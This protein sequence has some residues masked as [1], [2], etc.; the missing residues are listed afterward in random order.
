MCRSSRHPSRP[1]SAH[2]TARPECKE[3]RK[4]W[5]PRPQ[6]TT[7]CRYRAVRSTLRT[8]G[9]P[10]RTSIRISSAFLPPRT[11]GCST[12]IRTCSLAVG[13]GPGFSE[14]MDS[15][16]PPARRVGMQS[17]S[18]S[19]D[20]RWN[21]ALPRSSSG[22]RRDLLPAARLRSAPG[23]GQTLTAFLFLKAVRVTGLQAWSARIDR[24]PTLQRTR[25]SPSL[26]PW[27]ADVSSAWTF[28]GRSPACGRCTALA[29]GDLLSALA[30]S[31]RRDRGR[32]DSRR[33][34]RLSRYRGCMVDWTDAVPCPPPT[35]RAIV[36]RSRRGLERIVVPITATG[37]NVC[38][39][40]VR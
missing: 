23:C 7:I 2:S 5:R 18:R 24:N 20:G 17:A 25:R 26:N 4:R 33:T 8:H 14:A 16:Q 29:V 36:G 37:T 35:P 15:P 10:G 30:Q 3:N 27:L 21:P 12:S 9:K 32:A 39:S 6:P 28:W 34:A 1:V 31:H 11:I 40:R 19:A 13:A 22:I 38:W